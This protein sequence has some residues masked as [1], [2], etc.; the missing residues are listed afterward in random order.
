MR[1]VQ[2]LC[3][4]Q[5]AKL[6]IEEYIYEK[7]LEGLKLTVDQFVDLCILCGRDYCGSIKGQPLVP[8]LLVPLCASICHCTPAV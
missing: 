8:C 1:L 4:A 3:G 5:S 6:P 7:V 2:H